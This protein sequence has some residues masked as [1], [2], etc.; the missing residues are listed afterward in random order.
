MPRIGEVDQYGVERLVIRINEFKQSDGIDLYHG[1]SFPMENIIA[2][3]GSQGPMPIFDKFGIQM[4]A[5]AAGVCKIAK[6]GERL[7]M[8]T[9]DF[10]ST[11]KGIYVI[12]GAIS[13]SYM[14]IS[15]GTIAEEKHPNLIY[16][17]INDAYHVVEAIRSKIATSKP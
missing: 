7:V 5:C 15:G 14:K 2:C 17:A 8:L 6:E 10:E 3:I 13:P 1:M 9:S 12:G 16:T 4:I 11:R